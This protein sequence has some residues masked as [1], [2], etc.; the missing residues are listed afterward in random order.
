MMGVVIERVRQVLSREFIL[1]ALI[2]VSGVVLDMVLFAVLTEGLCWGYQLANWVSTSAG[3]TN[4]FLLNAFLNFKKRDALWGRY[5]KFYLVGCVGLALTALM[6][7]VG[8]DVLQAPAVIVKAVSLVVVLLVQ[9]GLN[10]R[11][12]FS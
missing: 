2:G 11:F 5:A 6:L 3:I 1:Y 8:V 12:S 4:N 7:W 9:Y 10:K